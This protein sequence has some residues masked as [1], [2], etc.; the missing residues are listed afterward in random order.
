MTSLLCSHCGP[1]NPW[2]QRHLA[3]VCVT[4]QPPPLSQRVAE[5]PNRSSS[6]PQDCVT[7][8]DSVAPSSHNSRPSTVKRR[9]HPTKSCDEARRGRVSSDAMLFTPPTYKSSL[10]ASGELQQNTDQRCYNARW[11]APSG[12]RYTWWSRVLVATNGTILWVIET[13]T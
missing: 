8:R 4:T 5:Q 12:H 2:A 1:T 9:R 10:P 3:A 6:A 7:P 11:V 13:P